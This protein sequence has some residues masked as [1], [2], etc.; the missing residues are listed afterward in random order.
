[1]TRPRGLGSVSLSPVG[2]KSLEV[3]PRGQYLG[4]YYSTASLMTWMMGQSAPAGSLWMVQTWEEWLVYQ[5]VGSP[6]RGT[7]TGW[8]ILLKV[9]KGKGG[10][11]HLGR[12]NLMHQPTL[13]TD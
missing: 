10:V 6:F 4:Q 1:M 9:N 7:S 8:R 2:S 3:N 13:G 11:L 5:M 12:N